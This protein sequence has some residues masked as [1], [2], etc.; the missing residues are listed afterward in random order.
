MYNWIQK[1][2]NQ[3]QFDT[4]KRQGV[5]PI[6][7]T[8]LSNRE[9][10]WVL[11]KRDIGT[12]IESNLDL[13]EPPENIYGLKEVCNFLLD[14]K[15]KDV[16]V[17][18]DYD[19]DGVISS[20]LCERLLLSLG[21][22]SVDTYLPS[23]IDDGY[24][25]NDD[26]I[27]NFLKICKKPYKLLVV[28]DCGTSSNKQIQ[29]IKESLNQIDI[30]IIDHH[31]VN[32][33]DFSTNADAICNPRL[34]D[35]NLYCTGGLMYQIANYCSKLNKKINSLN[36]L[37]YAAITTITDVCDLT[38]SNR[39]IV[40]NGLYKLKTCQDVGINEL[41][42]VVKVDKTK[43][44]TD[45]IAFYIGP[46]IN[47]SGRVKLAAKAFQLLRKKDKVQAEQ[48]AKYLY[49]LNETRKKIQK[50]VAEEAFS[51]CE[52]SIAGK[53]S[54][55]LYNEKWNPG[56]VGIVAS[57]LTE[58]FNVPAICFGSSKGVIKG[59][60]RSIMGINIK[61][62]MD[63]CSIIFKKHGG[64]EMAA[65]ATLSEEYVDTA[66]DIFDKEVKKYKEKYSSLTNCIEYDYEV[67]KELLV[68]IDSSFCERLSMLEPYGSANQEPVFICKDLY[69]R[70]VQMWRSGNGG[71]VKMDNTLIDCF[72]FIK[73]MKDYENKEVD[74]LFTLSMSFIKKSEWN[75]KIRE[76]KK[77]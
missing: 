76:V 47:A 46:L 26:S 75:I 48:I 70:K 23:R 54:I 16:V 14:C 34:N 4:L 53:D 61:Q 51:M 15:D 6:F 9:F 18:G 55:L 3:E 49:G 28:L 37:P 43:C 72:T 8:L 58:K 36:Y 52:S 71:F 35:S 22:K 24:G 20:Y 1:K 27:V 74:I 45:D 5:A 42:K 69:C 67:D 65:G 30:V 41:L 63:S 56:V 13:I 57:K 32:E 77:N 21:A 33:K 73:N 25:L 62:I 68:R 40:K 50:E 12:L 17:F 19:A 39:I 31:I 2:Y 29:K 10:P 11:T 59:S 60:A 38:G 7:C 44:T 64:H 66:W